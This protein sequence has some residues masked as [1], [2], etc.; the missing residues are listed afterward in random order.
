MGQV[1]KMFRRARAV[2]LKGDA[3]GVRRKYRLGAVGVRS[4]GVI[5]TAN[6]LSCR[7]PTPY[8]HAEAR[9]VR[10]LDFGS[11]VFVVR[12]QRNGTTVNARPCRDCEIA[13]RLRGVETC[14]YTISEKEWGV[15]HL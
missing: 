12:I 7:R 3:K 6:N 5:V 2:A 8:A 10:K 13:M 9:L 15:L 4:D 1:E 11:T 14:Y